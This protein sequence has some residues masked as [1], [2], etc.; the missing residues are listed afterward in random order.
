MPND[1]T[2]VHETK[3]VEQTAPLAA[4]KDLF[5]PD[6]IYECDNDLEIPSLR[7]DMQAKRCTIPFLAFGEQKRT[8][9]MNGTGTLHF[10]V[11]DYRWGDS[12]YQHPEKILKHNPMNII[13][14]NYSLFND[15]P[16]AFGMQAIYKKR[17]ISR[18]MQEKG[19]RVF[20]DLNVAS[21]FYKLN[22]IGIP[23]GWKAYATRGYSDRVHYL[24]FEHKLAQSWS[25]I[26]NPLFVVYGGG[27]VIKDYCRNHGLIYVTPM[28]VIKKKLKAV[29]EMSETVAF[30]GQELSLSSM[31]PSNHK[32]PRLEDIKSLQIEDYCDEKL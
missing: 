26:E 6:A 23:Q 24:E 21:K 30:F 16:I 8:Y 27:N 2:E 5:C 7:L 12:L 17:L 32:M 31:L 11:D 20:A 3:L 13:E 25:G 10:Y 19:I 4:E 14:P 1:L 18:Y 15:T 29:K 28:V 22:M 9:Q